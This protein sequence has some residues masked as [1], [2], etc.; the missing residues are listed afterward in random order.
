MIKKHN[1]IVRAEK[2]INS[3]I[4]SM[5]YNDNLDGVVEV[6]KENDKQGYVM[7]IYKDYNPENDLCVWVYEDFNNRTIHTIIGNHN[8]CDKLNHYV[9]EDLKYN[10]YPIISNIKKEI[11]SDLVEK[12][13]NHYNKSIK[14]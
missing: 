7:K 9:G 2:I 1:S 5:H 6:F 8:N 13:Y 10:E 11:V 12:I 14:L 3:F 4:N